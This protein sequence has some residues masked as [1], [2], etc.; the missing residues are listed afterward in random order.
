MQKLAFNLGEQFW[1]KPE[2]GIGEAAG[3]SS[4][5]KLISAI[6]PNVYIIAGIILFILLIG[7]GFMFI[8]GAGSDNP[9]Q[10]KKGRQAITAAL[11]GFG[12]IFASYWIIQIIETV[13]GVKILNPIF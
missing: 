13:T 5:G 10:A 7:G 8:V 12:V 9:E 2:A 3:Y 4:L 11:A 6:L 1:L